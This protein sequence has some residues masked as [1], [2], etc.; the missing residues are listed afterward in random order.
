[1]NDLLFM[2][3]KSSAKSWVKYFSLKLAIESRID[4][5]HHNCIEI[6]QNSVLFKKIS[7]SGFNIPILREVAPEKKFKNC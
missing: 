1:M 7:I 3:C 4:V 6:I 5:A 2:G